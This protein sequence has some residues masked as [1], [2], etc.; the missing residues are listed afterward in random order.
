M[1]TLIM[2]SVTVFS[3]NFKDK[4]ANSIRLVFIRQKGN[5]NILL[6]LLAKY[7]YSY[8]RE[9]E[10]NNAQNNKVKPFKEG[11]YAEE[12]MKKISIN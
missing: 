3:L 9:R 10:I 7:M 11:T 6:W 1:Q 2:H 8:L 12:L 4:K 5:H